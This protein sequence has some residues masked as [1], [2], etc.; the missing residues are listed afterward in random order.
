MKTDMSVAY[1]I[2]AQLGGS[3]FKMMTGAKDFIASQDALSFKIGSGAKNKINGVRVIL[4]PDDTYTVEF[5][6]LKRGEYTPPMVTVED[7]YNDNLQAIFTAETGF[8]TNL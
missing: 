1:T 3:R 6:R 8:Y 5:Y 7:V 2:L 4:K